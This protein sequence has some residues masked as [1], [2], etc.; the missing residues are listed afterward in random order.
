MQVLDEQQPG[1]SAVLVPRRGDRATGGLL[2]EGAIVRLAVVV[3][4]SPEASGEDQNEHRRTHPPQPLRDPGV[5]I[6]VN[7]RAEQRT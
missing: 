2:H 7:E 6:W 1:L 5:L 4:C 3:A